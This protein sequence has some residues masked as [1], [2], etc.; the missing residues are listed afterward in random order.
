MSGSSLWVA[1]VLGFIV[2]AFVGLWLIGNAVAAIVAHF[3]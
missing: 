2:T 3:I 1:V